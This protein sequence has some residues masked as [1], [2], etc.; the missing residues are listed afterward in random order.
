M[1]LSQ[2]DSW[3]RHGEGGQAELAEH[4]NAFWGLIRRFSHRDTED[5]KKSRRGFSVSLNQLF[6]PAKIEDA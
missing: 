6:L 4:S 2:A 5:T 1:E 3:R